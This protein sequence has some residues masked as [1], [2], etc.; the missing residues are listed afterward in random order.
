MR[1]IVLALGNRCR[2]AISVGLLT[3]LLASSAMAGEVRGTVLF[4][5]EILTGSIR[6]S[7]HLQ[8]E[9]PDYYPGA[10]VAEDG[11]FSFTFGA[12]G[13][14]TLA[15]VE[16]RFYVGSGCRVIT[17]RTLSLKADQV[18]IANFD[19]G[20]TAARFVG[21]VEVA[22]D[23]EEVVVTANYQTISIDHVGHFEL[24]SVPRYAR[25]GVA[26]DTHSGFGTGKRC[27]G[28]FSAPGAAGQTTDVGVL[29]FFPA[30]YADLEVRP[31]W[32]AEPV[33]L[34]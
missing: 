18:A 17:S 21:N 31:T 2:S 34:G 13:S 12:A 10:V 14:Y 6:N 15:V 25:F 33:E 19:L 24:L 4:N 11:T 28:F 9:G 29:A 5:G 30:H 8:L 1:V 20:S 16:G 7:I 32:R 23:A 27:H 26:E 22:P 3:L